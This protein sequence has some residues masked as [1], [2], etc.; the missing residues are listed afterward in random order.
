MT[1]ADETRDLLLGELLTDLDVP[2]H[3]PTFRDEL[4]AAQRQAAVAGVAADDLDGGGATGHAAAPGR[5]VSTPP[6]R[7]PARPE[8]TRRRRNRLRAVAATASLALTLVAVVAV[9]ATTTPRTPPVTVPTLPTLPTDTPPSPGSPTTPD[10][11]LLT[12]VQ[13]RA[14][15]GDAWSSIRTV[16]GE[17]VTEDDDGETR[18]G[19]AQT[20]AGDLRL[21]DLTRGGTIVYDAGGN[22][23]RSLSGSASMR[24]SEVLFPSE[25]RGLSAGAPDPA[26]ATHVLQARLGAVVRA[27]AAIDDSGDD[28]GDD[29]DGRVEEVTYDGRPAWR[30]STAVPVN[31]IV[32]DHS[33]DHLDVTVDQATGFPV[34]VVASNAGRRLYE[35]RVERLEVDVDLAP[36]TFQLTIPD[37]VADELIATDHGFEEVAIDRLEAVTGE[38]PIL[39]AWLPDGFERAEVRV[40]SLGSPTGTEGMNPA[41]APVVSMAFRRGLDLVVVSTRPLGDDPDAWTD[42]LGPGE[43]HLADPEVVDVDG[44]VLA[45]RRVELSVDLLTVPHLWARTDTHV[46]TVAG[47]L[48]RAELLQL[49]ASLGPA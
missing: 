21:D 49:A 44:G 6:T 29:G 20:A 36:D 22:L 9:I 12:A 48:T 13:V 4:A 8:P 46:V 32:P 28:G 23:E 15:V 41:T 17:L 19:F 5:R 45:G 25:R 30:L 1:D 26:P 27:L 47:D 31:L 40:S 24:D 37:E 34:R 7:P 11:E 18:W 14:V 3:R 2:E 42:P 35:M 33:P 10:P 43:G 16:R 39:P 38:R